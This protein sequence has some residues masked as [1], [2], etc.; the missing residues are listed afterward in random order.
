[1]LRPIRR[2]DRRL[3][4]AVGDTLA[5]VGA[6]VLAQWTWTLTAGYPFS[7]QFLTHHAQWFLAVPL[8]VIALSATRAPASRFRL[9]AAAQGFVQASGVLFGAYLLAFFALGPDRLP[10]LLA[11]YVLWDAAWLT[12]AVRAVLTTVLTRGGFAR[13]VAIVGTGPAVAAASELLREPAFADA[14]LVGSPSPNL[15]DSVDEVTDVVVAGH[16]PLPPATI[17]GLL[18]CQAQGIDVGTF[19]HLHEQILRR[20][21]V[22][23]VGHEWVLTQLF[24]S[25]LTRDRSQT[26]KRLIDIGGA[27]V[28][29][30]VGIVP[31][32][33]AAVAVLVES[34]R[35][36]LYTQIRVGRG[37]RLFRLTKLRTMRVDAEVAGPQWSPVDDPRIT[38]VGRILRR[39]HLDE[40][41]NVWA[42]L[43]GDMSLVGPRPERPEFVEN[44][45]RDVPLYRSRLTVTPGLTGWAQVKTEY[46]DSVDDAVRKL[47]YDL[48][49]VRHQSIWFDAV[50]LLRTVGRMVGWR[51]R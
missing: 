16:E 8:W 11:I 31:C 37:G 21:P 46:G 42:I 6:V 10:R 34:G 50:I 28:L 24:S 9:K 14:V 27:S 51:G 2:S 43:R 22:R 12:L 18:Q 7:I 17:E 4:F 25:D 49:Y 15:P 40:L 45:E 35:P 23:Y 5:A 13:R 3:L 30:L 19:E 36:V 20:V 44:L 32:L 39:T 48:Y 26:L 33:L 38:R 1:M 29:A 41:P 47:E